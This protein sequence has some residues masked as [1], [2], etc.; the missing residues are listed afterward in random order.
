MRTALE[1]LP[2]DVRDVVRL[3]IFDQKTLEETAELLGLGTSATLRRFRKGIG[4]YHHLLR[5][6]LS[7][8]TPARRPASYARL[9]GKAHDPLGDLS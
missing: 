7:S 8:R 1:G 2:D 6:V 4:L 3:R 9:E 5:S